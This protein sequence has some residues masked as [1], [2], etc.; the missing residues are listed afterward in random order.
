M[1]KPA[2]IVLGG[3]LAMGFCLRLYGAWTMDIWYDEGTVYLLAQ[4][5]GQNIRDFFDP[6]L[7][8]EKPPISYLLLY[9]WTR[10][11]DSIFFAKLLSVFSGTVSIALVYLIG[12]ETLDEKAALAA[13][14]LMSFSPYELLYSIEMTNN[15]LMQTFALASMLYF[16]RFL[17]TGARA[18]CVTAIGFQFIAF[19]TIYT[20]VFLIISQNLLAVTALRRRKNLLK[21]WIAVQAAALTP[22]LLWIF[23]AWQNGLSTA[24]EFVTGWVPLISQAGYINFF[25]PLVY[26]Y[27]IGNIPGIFLFAPLAIV[28]LVALSEKR[29]RAFFVYFFLPFIV[30]LVASQWRNLMMQR[31]LVA[32]VPALFLVIAAG[33]GRLPGRIIKAAI[34]IWISAFLIMSS[35]SY[36]RNEYGP[37]FVTHFKRKEYYKAA[38]FLDGRAGNSE[39]IYHVSQSSTTVFETLRREKWEHKWVVTRQSVVDTFVPFEEYVER[40]D[41]ELAFPE[42]WNDE[43]FAGFDEPAWFVL[44]SF[45]SF[46]YLEIHTNDFLYRL[47]RYAV[48]EHMERLNY[49]DLARYVPYDVSKLD[50]V[51][52][53]SGGA[54]LYV[55]RE[56]GKPFPENY[57]SLRGGFKGTEVRIDG[58]SITLETKYENPSLS[59]EIIR[60]VYPFFPVIK[61]P[62]GRDTKGFDIWQ[63]VIPPPRGG[64]FLNSVSFGA[65]VNGPEER[66]IKGGAEIPAGSYELLL[67]VYMEPEDGN[68][69]Y[70]SAEVDGAPIGKKLKPIAEKPRWG[71]LSMGAFETLG[72][73]SIT[74]KAH[75]GEGG[76]KYADI[77]M[78]IVSPVDPEGGAI[79]SGRIKV[80]ENI[81]LNGPTVKFPLE[82]RAEQGYTIAIATDEERREILVVR[83][84]AEPISR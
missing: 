54:R 35:V 75:G 6:S 76:Q 17:K 24:V 58:H 42:L 3:I 22:L 71:W 31:Y 70:I 44:S 79:Q 15:G 63:L 27:F 64:F 20:A 56:S 33:W 36:F 2:Y 55:D 61:E 25:N 30:L 32:Y 23:F 73:P 80:M 45:S 38:A 48:Q 14:A 46:P 7:P 84:M 69:A 40:M 57:E 65:S 29:A 19:F 5:F 18:S 68:R 78:M 8:N 60:D 82:M 34:A 83:R 37:D 11:G 77:H 53:E 50:L 72:K 43:T 47:E 49:L 59:L 10:M 66:H 74:I 28:V 4:K 9:L 39:T 41:I 67:R 81:T 21:L 13:S 62:A 1:K 52:S 16:A 26:G 12:R 51:A